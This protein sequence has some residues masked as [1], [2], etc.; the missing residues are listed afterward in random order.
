MCNGEIYNH[1]S[2]RD[3]YKLKTQS[4]SD[5]SIVFPLFLAL[6]EDFETLNR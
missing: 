3:K 6:K 1:L 2:I 4:D 5:C